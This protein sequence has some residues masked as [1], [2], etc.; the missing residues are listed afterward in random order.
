MLKMIIIDDERL[1]RNGLADYLDWA[2]MG[3][4]IS[5]ICANGAEGLEA[6]HVHA[7][8]IVLTDIA[9]PI[10]DGV[11]LLKRSRSEGFSGQFIFISSYSEFRYA[12]E[13]VKYNAFDYLLKPL[14]AS[15]LEESVRRCID[16]IHASVSS[17]KPEHNLRSARDLL[18]ETLLGIPHTEEVLFDWLRRAAPP[19]FSPLLAISIGSSTAFFPQVAESVSLSCFLSPQCIAILL[20]NEVALVPLQVAHPNIQWHMHSCSDSMHLTLCRSLLTLWLETHPVHSVDAPPLSEDAWLTRLREAAATAIR[21]SMDLSACRKVL[22]KMLDTLRRQVERIGSAGAAN[23]VEGIL[24]NQN[25]VEHVYALFDCALMTGM[26]LLSIVSTPD[27][28]APYTRKAVALIEN[29]PSKDLSL[30]AVAA[31]LG[32]SKSHLSATFKA[33]MGCSFSDYIF[34]FRMKLAK[35][36][37]LQEKYKIYEIAERVGY[38]DLAQFSKRFKQYYGVSPR[39]MQRRM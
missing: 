31:Q 27:S 8:S 21:E 19:F 3:I 1:I 33:D 10:M 15:V 30:G 28:L 37:L 4:E 18:R 32:I 9:M 20:P 2:S 24:Q 5:A 39:K 26:H 7:P 36:L 29:Q 11:E 22:Q 12:Q 34:A 38:S 13:A 23:A 25:D 6:I 16:T 14:E 17:E 35:E